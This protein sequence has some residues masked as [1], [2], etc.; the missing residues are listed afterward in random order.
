[1]ITGDLDLAE[2]LTHDAYELGVASGQPE[3]RLFFATTLFGIRFEQCRLAEVAA[4]F[5]EMITSY[6]GV[7]VVRAML[8][9]LYTETDRDADA[10]NCFEELAASN[11]GAV[12]LDN[13]WLQTLCHCAAMSSHLADRA[14]ATALLDLLAPYSTQIAGTPVGWFG[15]VAHYLAIVASALGRFD[16]AD[17]HFAAA[18]AIHVRIGAP[19]WLSRTRMEWARMLLACRQPRDAERARELLRQALT[20]ARELGLGS[21]ER[22]TVGLLGGAMFSGQPDGD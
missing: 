14:R 17:A 18:A 12:P 7:P 19:I 16:E 21:L 3:A 9:L 1:V 15:S 6:S 8:G 4:R 2:R 13:L 10:S 20:T 5:T 11:F 22:R